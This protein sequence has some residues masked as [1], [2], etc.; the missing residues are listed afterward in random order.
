MHL[1]KHVS[2]LSS[3]NIKSRSDGPA[4]LQPRWSGP[5]KLI[6]MV[7]KRPAELE[8][9][10]I[11]KIHDVFHGFLRKPF[12]VQLGTEA[13]PVLYVDED[14]ELDVEHIRSHRGSKRTLEYLVQYTVQWRASPPNMTL[15]SLLQPCLPVLLRSRAT[16]P[17]N[18]EA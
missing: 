5:F 17:S 11:V 2:M 13:T 15:G 1:A 10:R 16:G 18:I 9:P 6:S 3:E 4:K 7:G 8:L 14:Q 12:T